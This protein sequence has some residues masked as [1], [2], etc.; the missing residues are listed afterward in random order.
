MYSCRSRRLEVIYFG[1]SHGGKKIRNKRKS[2]SCSA[3]CETPRLLL[4]PHSLVTLQTATDFRRCERCAVPPSRAARTAPRL[5]RCGVR[6]GS[7][8][9]GNAAL[10]A[11][12]TSVPGQSCRH[13]YPQHFPGRGLVW[14]LFYFYFY[15]SKCRS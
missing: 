8:R 11:L 9:H 15:F 12:L 2:R 6:V 10:C 1:N 5:Q 4:E 7:A 14:A 3:A 13:S